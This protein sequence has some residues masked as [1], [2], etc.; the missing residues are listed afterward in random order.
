MQN[1]S[2]ESAFNLHMEENNAPIEMWNSWLT[3]DITMVSWPPIGEYSRV[4]Y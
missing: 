1:G 2:R 3:F 4:H